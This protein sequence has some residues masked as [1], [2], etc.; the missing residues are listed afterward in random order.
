MYFC[1]SEKKK[2]NYFCINKQDREY[3][4][5]EMY[6]Q[7]NCGGDGCARSVVVQCVHMHKALAPTPTTKN[8]KNC[9]GWAYWMGRGPGPLIVH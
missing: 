7:I 3:I 1:V 2:Q 8:N 5:I 9:K 4:N 6:V